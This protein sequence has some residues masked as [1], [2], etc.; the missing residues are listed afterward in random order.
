MPT[1]KHY[2]LYLHFT[3]QLGQVQVT[4][5][6]TRRPCAPSTFPTATKSKTTPSGTKCPEPYFAVPSIKLEHA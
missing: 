3:P 5:A 1:I 6:L 2:T 4:S